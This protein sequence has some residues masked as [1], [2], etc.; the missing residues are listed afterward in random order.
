MDKR[1][2][3]NTKLFEIK[4]LKCGSTNCSIEENDLCD[5]EDNVIG[6]SSYVYCNDC[7]NSDI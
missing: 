6:I 2:G 5:E 4:C 3:Y 1:E 7:H